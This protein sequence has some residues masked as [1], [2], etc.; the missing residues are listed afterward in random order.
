[1]SE[2]PTTPPNAPHAG[3]KIGLLALAVVALL[4]IA[5]S[6]GGLVFWL[7]MKRSAP[8]TKNGPEQI[9]TRDVPTGPLRAGAPETSVTELFNGT[10]LEGWDFDPAVWSVRNGVIHGNKR[11]AGA[12]TSLF[13]R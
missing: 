11:R 2:P 3:L 12:G 7:V 6:F 4:V 10:D 9:G 8:A 1:M 5:L 13:W